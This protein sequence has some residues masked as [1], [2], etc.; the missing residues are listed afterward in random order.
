ML[1]SCT[2]IPCHKSV[3]SHPLC[4]DKEPKHRLFYIRNG[5]RLFSF[6]SGPSHPLALPSPVFVIIFSFIRSER[7]TSFFLFFLCLR[8][9]CLQLATFSLVAFPAVW[10]WSSEELVNHPQHSHMIELEELRDS[11]LIVMQL[12]PAIEKYFATKIF[13]L[14]LKIGC[15]ETT[16]IQ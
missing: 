10:L 2:V 9:V 13:K 14:N 16:A 4:T 12:G 1:L 8:F 6:M 15:Q 3:L 11:L 5:E 7:Q